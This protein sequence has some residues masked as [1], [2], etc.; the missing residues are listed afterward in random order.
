[1]SRMKNCWASILAILCLFLWS[2]DARVSNQKPS[3]APLVS[4]E[5]LIQFNLQKLEAQGELLDSLAMQW[6]WV[7]SPG[8][9][10]L[11]SG[12]LVAPRVR[13]ALEPAQLN[14]PII[15]S[16]D[17]VYWLIEIRLVDSTLVMDSLWV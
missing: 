12:L 5:D 6:G 17:S 4:A 1:M 16:G 9:Q 10:K 3:S 2:C 15:F 11:G 7:D 14:S 8:Y 13:K